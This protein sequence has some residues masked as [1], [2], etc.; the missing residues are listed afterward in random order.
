MSRSRVLFF[1]LSALLVFPLMAATL[2][3]AA[4]SDT[5]QEEDSFYKYLAIFSEVLGYVRQ[6]H[7]DEPNMNALM[8]GA[9]DGTT[10]ALDPFSL[11]IPA[12]QVEGYLEARAV[13]RRHSGLTLLKESGIAYVVSVEQGSPAGEAGVRPGDIVSK[14]GD[15][16]TRLMPL[17]EIQEI[18]AG[19]PGTPVSLDLLRLGEPVKAAF[20]LK[21]FDA[22]PPSLETVE[23]GVVLLRIPDFSGDAAAQARDLLAQARQRAGGRGML[24]DLRGVSVG[25][26]AAAYE[27]A[28]LFADGDLGALKRRGEEVE[29][30][31]GQAAPL[32]QGKLVL[33]IDRGTLGP[34]EIFAS[35]LRQKLKAELV[36]E[37]TFGYAGRQE[38]AQLSTGGRLLLTD[39]FYTGPDRVILNESLRPDLLVSERVRTYL[40]RDVTIPELILRR[41]VSRLL[42]EDSQAAAKKAA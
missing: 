20:N 23:K 41:G 21:P 1:L 36:G 28:K 4:D 35:V 3:Q 40:E 17:W 29:T 15:R 38:M 2:L 12:S 13:G 5:P 14:I 37:R 24:I 11:Y 8:A 32:W 25:D 34:A 7:V 9:L 31:K 22:P 6:A 30:Y 18:M 33:L 16:S 27:M 39:A 19:K 10:D 42:G 26:P